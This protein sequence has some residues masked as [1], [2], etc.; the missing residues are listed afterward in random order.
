MKQAIVDA[1]IAALEQELALRLNANVQSNAGAAFSAA[2]AEKQRDTTGYEAA[3][4]ARGHAMH[5]I[6]LRHRIDELKAME[7]EDFTGQEIDLGAIAEVEMD[8]AVDGY[9]LLNCGGGTEV[10]VDGKTI[11]VITPESPLGS[12]LMGNIEA[13]FIE[14]PS[15]LEGII[16]DVY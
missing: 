16:L 11:T 14:L 7:V 1:V 5:A 13:G 3:H 6:H 9:M 2:G 8:G 10:E 4:L 12:R 15:G